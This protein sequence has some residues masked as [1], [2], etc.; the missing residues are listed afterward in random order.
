LPLNTNFC[1]AEAAGLF[2]LVKKNRVSY[3]ILFSTVVV[4]FLFTAAFLV[5]L[6]MNEPE[7]FYDEKALSG[8]EVKNKAVLHPDSLAHLLSDITSSFNQLGPINSLIVSQHGEIVTE[9]YYGR[10]H[11]GRGQNIKSASKSVLSILVGIA[12]DKGYL[13]G[14][15][16]TIE[17]FFPEYFTTNPDSLKASITIEDLLTM[18]SGLA[19]TSRANYGKWVTSSNW[20]QYTLER[21]LQGTPGSGSNL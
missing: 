5:Y 12:I 15:D 19:S 17:E 9:Q 10:M 1:V 18:R 13:E 7:V 2:H 4:S 3:I 8:E 11:G 21:P 6:P 16:Q 14:V 20:I